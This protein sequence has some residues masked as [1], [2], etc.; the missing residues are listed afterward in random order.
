MKKLIPVFAIVVFLFGASHALA[1][2]IEL[3]EQS[4]VAQGRVLAVRALLNDPSTVFYNSAGLAYLDGFSFA[5]GDTMA[6]PSFN[7]SDPSGPG[8]HADAQNTNTVVPPPHAYAAYGM[9]LGGNSRLGVGLG[10]NVPFG[11]TLIWPEDFAGRHLVQE[12]A[13]MCPEITLG[14]AYSPVKQVSIG[15][16]FVASPAS[17]YLKRYLGQNFGLVGDDGQPIDDAFVEMA[18]AGWGFGFAAGIQ[19]RPVERLFLGFAYR[20]GISIEMEGDAHFELPGLSDKSGFP[21]QKVETKFELPD[22][23]AF[24][25]GYQIL[26]A[27]YMEFDLDYAFWSVFDTIPLEFP[28]DTTGK[29]SQ[30]LPQHWESGFTFRLGNEVTVS[31]AL[32]LRGGMGYDQNPIPDD[33]LSPMLPDAGRIFGAVGAG[34]ALDM[35][36]RLDMAYELTYF[37][38][39]TVEGQPCTA[40]APCTDSA[41]NEIP[42]FNDAGARNWAG[43]PFPANY[44]GMAQ[45]LSVTL[46]MAF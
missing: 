45:L 10:V 14:A 31:R 32:T 8:G 1:A 23:L 22:K 12:S 34:Y 6:F 46:G 35:G 38:E 41:G 7:Y 20:S 11:L 13:L 9:S 4:A 36:L 29:L 44:R 40:E 42:E 28:E 17:V 15:A 37:R 26:N 2:G 16:A 24:G 19:A 5:L 27:W 33:Y 21:D 18:G 25:I 39:R 3:E 30:E 43:N